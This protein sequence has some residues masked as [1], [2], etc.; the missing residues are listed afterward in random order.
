MDFVGPLFC[1][2]RITVQRVHDRV[3]ARLFMR[4]ARRQEHEHVAVD[5]VSFQIAFQRCSV[6]FYVLHGHRLR[7]RDWRRHVSLHLGSE[8]RQRSKNHRE[9]YDTT[10]FRFN[11]FDP[12][13]SS[14]A[15]TLQSCH[16]SQGAWI[17]T[18]L[19]LY[20]MVLSGLATATSPEPC[21][22]DTQTILI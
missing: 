1:S 6:N 9:R 13:S 21:P 12:L 5:R 22:A 7:T 4:V 8:S 3:A 11:H 2:D 10:Q 15:G 20:S 18:A 14:P 16:A 19:P 17:E